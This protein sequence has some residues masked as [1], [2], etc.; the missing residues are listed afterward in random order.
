MSLTD[1]LAI[2]GAATGMTGTV[3][4]VMSYRRD[5]ARLKV[6]TWVAKSRIREGDLYLWVRIHN[7][8]RQPAKVVQIMALRGR[9]LGLGWFLPLLRFEHAKRI[10]SAAGKLDEVGTFLDPIVDKPAELAPNDDWD[11]SLR[12]ATRLE[13]NEPRGRT[14]I[15]AVTVTE[16]IIVKRLTGC[17]DVAAWVSD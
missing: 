4:G 15:L 6:K 12:G 9:F 16:S 5:R 10:L 17:Q 11:A 7:A 1:V 14:Y 13:A 2:I 3:L 8:G